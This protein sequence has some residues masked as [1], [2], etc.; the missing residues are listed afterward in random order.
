[1]PV[2]T[3]TRLQLCYSYRADAQFRV[4]QAFEARI[5]RRLHVGW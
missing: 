4:G 5:L 1:M 3:A 2:I